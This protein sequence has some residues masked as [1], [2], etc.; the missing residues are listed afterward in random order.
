M[1]IRKMRR[2]LWQNKT[3]FLSIFLMSFLGLLIFV[4]L[5]AEVSGIKKNRDAYYERTNLADL[6]VIGNG[7]QEEDE[8][9]LLEIG[10][11]QKA[12]RRMVADG[13]VKLSE[14]YDVQMNF[15]TGAE[16]S[17][18]EIVQGEDFSPEKEGIW[19][20]Y[21]FVKEHK[22]KMGD[23]I[24]LKIQNV[25][26]DVILKGSFYHPEYVYYLPDAN[27]MM[28][29]Y[30]KY[31]FAFLGSA[32]FPLPS[33]LSYNQIVLDTTR[34]DNTDGLDETETALGNQLKQQ[35]DNTLNRDGI[36]ISDK[37]QLL[38]YQTFDSEVAQHEVMAF[39]FP[40]VF[41]LIAVLGIVTTMARM[42]ANQRIQIGTLKALGFTKKKITFHYVFYGFFLSMLGSVCGAI[43]GY[44][45]IPDL[46]FDTMKA[47]YLIPDWDKLF[48]LKSFGAIAL[49]V[50][51]SS[52]VSYF[53]C[54][55]ELSDPPAETLKPAVPKKMKHSAF[56]KSRLW[57]EMNF[58][59][60][61]NVRDILRNKMRT[62]MGIVGVI[63]CTMLL[64]CAFGCLDTVEDITG[65]MYGEL[66]TCKTKIILEEKAGD[67]A[68]QEYAA[69]YS[70]QVIQE[71]GIEIFSED[72]RKTGTITVLD[73][74]NYMHYQDERR[75]HIRLKEG[76]IAISYKMAQGL[77]VGAGD[78]I[79]WHVIG[80][81]EWEYTRIDQIYRTP[82]AQGIT[83][84]RD[85]FEEMEHV[86]QPTA[87][88]T[89]VSV[90]KS[91]ADEGDV[92]GVQNMEDMMKALE[93]N[94]QMMYMMVGILIFAAVVLGVVVLY[95]LGVLSFVE[96]TREIATL[97]V[98]GFRLGTIRWILQQQ[99][100][101]VTT[102][103][104]LLGLPLGYA[105]LISLFYGMPDSMD[106][107]AVIKP[108]SF[109]YS[110][111]GTYLVSIGVNFVLSGRVKTIN[112]V[113]ALKGAE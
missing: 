82:S 24:T 4:G 19:L 67:S 64:V 30:G 81:K 66:M 56:E 32:Q 93:T 41:L 69:K 65:W 99:N 49:A 111:I 10:S 2:D 100:L 80:E 1:L 52:A 17:F 33:L 46:L 51:V 21:Y 107:V 109:L 92:S 57:L 43:A 86:F 39:A 45:S 87:V 104:I 89:N 98:L 59:A 25:E 68:G 7:F 53:A 103:G 110:V 38:S 62:V 29:E 54:R 105:F 40:V 71:T 84:S 36:V 31:G 55:K 12:E 60:Q 37:T 76:G 73:T 70:G 14:D 27:A 106:Y 61:W 58:T 35:I 50:L 42:T 102:A 79:R 96:K 28:P 22:L 94:M 113:D 34:M 9:K 83:V 77:D 88:L 101:W 18:P 97:K 5:D 8:K 26:F 47:V 23:I 63:G 108:P 75:N 15:L 112:M 95:N 72:K 91:L 3:Q 6:W 48:S 13:T 16:V 85:T 44:M 78:F 11:I 20:D 74:G 90:P